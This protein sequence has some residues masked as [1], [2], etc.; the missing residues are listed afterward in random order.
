M[1]VLAPTLRPAE[2]LVPSRRLLTLLPGIYRQRD[3]VI[4]ADVDA[5]APAPLA[6]LV[7]V[8]GAGLDAVY[9]AISRLWDDHFV[10]RAEA[11]ALP[12]LAELY[13]VRLLS[14]DPQAQRA[15]IARIVGW[16][17]RKGTLTTLE[18]VLS[19]TSTWDV[20]VDEGFR[21]VL[22]SLDLAHL[23]PWRGRTAIVWD[24]IGLSD[25]LTRRSPSEA[26][27]RNDSRRE[28][29]LVLAPLPGER[30]D[31]TLRRLGRVDAGMYAASPR[32]LD[33]HGWVRPD[34]VLIRVS[35]LV[36]VE[37]EE[38]EPPPL[39]ALP[40][41]QRGG[42]VDPA[43]RDTP[44]VWLHPVTRPDLEG[45]L[46][47]RHEP[48]PAEEPLR[49]A[50]G[51][52][53][54][55]ALA[56]DPDRAERAGAFQ[57]AVDGVPLVG[58]PRPPM[59]RG[60]LT[61]ERVGDTG[62]VRFA[63]AGRPSPGDLWRISV[64]AAL[65]EVADP[66][67]TDLLQLQADLGPAGPVGAVTVTPA[68]GQEVQGHAVD[69]IVE[70]RAGEARQ[71]AADGTWSAL[72][73][74]PALGPAAS[75]AATVAVGADTWVAR[76]ERDL[77]AGANRLVRFVV[78]QAGWTV[79]RA[80]PAPLDVAD[81]IA[82]VGGDGG[83]ALY[84]VTGAATTLGVWRIA[85]LAGA[86]TVTR[87]DADSPRRPIAR[88][89]PSLCIADGRLYVYG[90]DD[91][92]AAAGD[93]WSLP[94]AGGPWRPHPLRRQ[95]ERVGATLV[96]TPAGLALVGG[97]AVP[98][99]LTTSC[100]LW[101]LAASRTWRPLPSLP[102]DTGG[103]GLVV[104]RASADGIEALA[105][106]D[107]TRP[108]RCVL[109]GGAEAW[110]VD[111][112]EA[113]APNVPAPGEA[114]F[115]GDALLVIGPAPL[116]VSDAV[117]TQGGQG[118]LAVLPR[119]ALAVGEAVRLR[120]A[121][122]GATFR[123]DPP[124]AA[125][126]ARPRPLDTRFGGLLAEEVLAAPSSDGRY[127]QPGRLA[128]RPWRLAQR[129][130]GPWDRLVGP[131]PADDGAVFLDPRLGRFVL[132]PAAPAGRVTVSCRVGRGGALG[133]GLVPPGRVIPD[134]WREPDLEV[135]MPP[136]LVA[137]PGGVGELDPHAYVAPHRAGQR[138]RGPE[139][140][141]I[142]V[143][144]DL[145]EAMTQVPA[146]QPP[147]F[148]VLGSARVPF[149]RLTAGVDAGLSLVAADAGSTP[150]L[151][152]DDERDLSLL[153]QTSAENAPAYWLAGLWLLGRLEVA[154]E[155]G[156]VDVRYCQIA[157]PG[158]IS[159]WAPGAG[160]QDLA[161]RRSLPHAEIEIRLYGCQVGVVELP[162]WA[163]L[164]A[165][166]CTFDAGARDAVAIRA[167][168]ATVRLRHSTIHGAVEAGRL[169]ASSC[170]FAGEVRVDRD[171]LGFVR[172]SLLARGG[173]TPRPYLSLGHTVSFVTLDPTSPGYLVLADNNGPG[174]LAVGEGTATPGAYGE[175]GDHERELSARTHEFLPIGMDPA[176]IDRTAF[177]LDRMARR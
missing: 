173:R 161:S 96:V 110:H 66:V 6:G 117:F 29:G 89:S 53:T 140:G 84:A 139:G 72:A 106:A 86:V 55:T 26:R 78:G 21:S 20:E 159:V 28:R 146:G 145:D 25:P 77:A 101:D 158:R 68:A 80:L 170:A 75:N 22:V 19:E 104:A 76:I 8:V 167:A 149:A 155:R 4:A 108:V 32:T 123:R 152:R 125:E 93:V 98:G 56:E 79:V 24:P 45:G 107:R 61:A 174:A 97:D 137:R 153:V 177:D 42:F 165:A 35:R 62:V 164:V 31:D 36:P 5:P 27:P 138:A 47:A 40:H 51:L 46:T 16:R 1:S 54:P 111:G 30:I 171:D 85:D 133:P 65:P 88:R 112:I 128:R 64:L 160:H 73:L 121:T 163:R 81:G 90:G 14:T 74:D 3:A 105:W 13:G 113:A 94:I 52:L 169:E 41:D 95:E 87:I 136:D 114:L 7:Q 18:D 176:P 118:V 129:S 17:R 91:N 60:A 144:A 141:T 37:L 132:P 126:A 135:A 134:D 82:L 130:L 57:L 127:A 69:L 49:V 109:P 50:A 70:R 2:A 11:L 58:P 71:R 33:L 122:D 48:A 39:T 120:V 12:L 10:E 156:T 162:P 38:I 102:F 43:G 34:A 124:S 168:G 92:G 15:L 150:V 143:L 67:P 172:H 147:R 119:L 175:R 83:A 103:P 115:V 23:A 166:G 59:P 116:P 99:T 157:G 148:A 44:L 100:R 142:G 63:E 131:A 151:D 154:V 9:D